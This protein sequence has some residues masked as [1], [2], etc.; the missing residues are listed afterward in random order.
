MKFLFTLFLNNKK[1]YE[2]T[3]KKITIRLFIV[4]DLFLNFRVII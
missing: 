3:F 1:K 4:A 2:N